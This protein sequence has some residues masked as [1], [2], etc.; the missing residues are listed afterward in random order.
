M[1]ASILNQLIIGVS[2]CGYPHLFASPTPAVSRW[3]PGPSGSFRRARDKGPSEQNVFFF[4]SE[5]RFG[6]S[7]TDG[8]RML[9]VRLNNRIFY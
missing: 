1:Y 9:N 2:C 4:C 7:L 6:K 5:I 8:T 3:T